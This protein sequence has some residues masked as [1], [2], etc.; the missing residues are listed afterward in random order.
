MSIEIAHEKLF[1]GVKRV[2]P[3]CGEQLPLGALAS[4]IFAG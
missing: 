4:I 3:S 1:L 2:D